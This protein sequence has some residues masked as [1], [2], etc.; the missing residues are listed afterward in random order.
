MAKVFLDTNKLIDIVENR[1]EISVDVFDKH[2]LFISPLSTHILLYT[3]K[4]KV[5]YEKL[6]KLMQEISIVDFDQ[7]ICYKSME[8]PTEDF[9]DN[10]QLHSASDADCDV[11]L[12]NDKRLLGLKFLGRTKIIQEFKN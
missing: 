10:V 3:T 8:G 7:S 12:T 9:E 5:P 2:N 4:H 11:F 6:E 1:R